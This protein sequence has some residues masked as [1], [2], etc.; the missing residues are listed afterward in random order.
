MCTGGSVCVRAGVHAYGREH[1][2]MGGNACV[3]APVDAYERA[4]GRAS[5]QAGGRR[6][7]ELANTGVSSRSTR[8]TMTASTQGKCPMCKCSRRADCVHGPQQCRQQ[9]M[10]CMS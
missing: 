3:R 8:H 7:G 4:S 1:V 6:A 5:E 10:Y 2:R 9:F